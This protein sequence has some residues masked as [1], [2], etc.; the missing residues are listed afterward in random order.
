MIRLF[1]LLTVIAAGSPLLAQTAAEL[2]QLLETKKVSLAQASR[3]VL[4]VAEVTDNTLEAGPAYALAEERG[5]LPE[6]AAPDTPI[7]LGE[8]CFLTM[9]AFGIRGS[10]LYVLS[11]GPRYAYR[12]LDYLKLIPGRR[13][14]DLTVSGERLLLILDMVSRYRG[15]SR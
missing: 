4:A 9:R 1:F 10:F 2:D 6:G 14:P 5:W 13:D 15:E 7:R 3:F 8:L 11:P 12:E